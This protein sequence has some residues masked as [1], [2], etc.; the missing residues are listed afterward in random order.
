MGKTNTRSLAQVCRHAGLHPPCAERQ[1]SGDR[2]QMTMK[3]RQTTSE[4]LP[5]SVLFGAWKCMQTDPPD[6]WRLVAWCYGPGSY[7]A[8]YYDPSSRKWVQYGGNMECIAKWW[9]DFPPSPNS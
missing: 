4:R 9:A 2:E 8:G 6:S 1:G 5:A 3:T 7:A